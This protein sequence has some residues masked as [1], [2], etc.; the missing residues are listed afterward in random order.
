MIINNSGRTILLLL[1]LLLHSQEARR[2]TMKDPLV[3]RN[4][5]QALHLL[6]I[7]ARLPHF[8]TA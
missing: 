2:Q 7:R 4:R 3:P 1:L 5:R 8:V 6:V